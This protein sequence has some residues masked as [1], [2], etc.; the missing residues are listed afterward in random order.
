MNDLKFKGDEGVPMRTYYEFVTQRDALPVRPIPQ[1]AQ[2][3][4]KLVEGIP[5][6][7]DAGHEGEC[8]W[9]PF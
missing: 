2:K 1:S 7:N 9:V 8:D 3:C 4:G 6:Q 5:C